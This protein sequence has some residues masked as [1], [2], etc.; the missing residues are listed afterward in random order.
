MH[1]SQFIRCFVVIV[2]LTLAVVPA[3][4]AE[5]RLKSQCTPAGEVV[6][7]GDIADISSTDARQAA[8]LAAIELFPAPAASEEKTVRVREI[9]DLLLLHGVNLA[10]HQVSGASEVVV[11]AAA[12]RPHAAAPRAMSSAEV[13]RQAPAVRGDRE[14]FERTFR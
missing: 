9:Q 3:T 1:N 6:T 13:Q 5:L 11:Q 4:A 8:T 14:V 12:A 7:L 2:G 10:E